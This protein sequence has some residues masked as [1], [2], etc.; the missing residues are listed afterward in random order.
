MA[1]KT[2]PADPSPAEV[3]AAVL[4]FL[5]ANLQKN[6]SKR[7]AQPNS[8]AIPVKGDAPISLYGGGAASRDDGV[9]KQAGDS[10]RWTGSGQIT[11]KVQVDRAGDY[12]VA[13]NHAAEPGAVGQQ[14][15]IS[16]GN[17]KVEYKLAMTK[18]VFGSKSYEMTPIKGRL[19]LEAGTQMITLSIPDAPKTLAVLQFRSLELIPVAAKAAIEAERTGGAAGAGQHGVAGQSRLRADVPLDLAEHRQGRNTQAVCAGR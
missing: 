8:T 15:Q 6:A 14:L 3:D 12:E 13:L 5:D 11:W 2:P 19:R 18:G 9:K 7:A 1:R 4:K 16:S 17:S 10:F